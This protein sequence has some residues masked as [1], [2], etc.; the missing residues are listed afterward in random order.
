MESNSNW[1]TCIDLNSIAM[2]RCVYACQD[3]ESCENE[4]VAEFKDQQVNCPCEVNSYF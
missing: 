2:G 3:D 4:C 1:N